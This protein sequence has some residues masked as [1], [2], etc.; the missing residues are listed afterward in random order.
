MTETQ[1]APG[2]PERE[3]RRAAA[4]DRYAIVGTPAEPAFD[5]LCQ[6]AAKLLRAPAA[7]VVFAD[8]E[9]RWCKSS[10]GFGEREAASDTALVEETINQDGVLLIEDAA[11]DPR[12]REDGWVR[13]LPKVRFFAGA[14]L[15]TPEGINVGALAVFD[16]APR[17][18]SDLDCDALLTLAAVVMD[19]AELRATVEN[20]AG[21]RADANLA[22]NERLASLGT[23]AAG[24]AHEI[25]N[26]L[27][28]VLANVGFVADRL[29]RLGRSL[30]SGITLKWADELGELGAALAEA[31]EGALR[32]RRIVR[33]LRIFSQND[34][35]KP[36]PVNLHR[37]LE[38]AITVALNEIGPRA[39]LIR[40]FGPVPPVDANEARLAQLF[41]N[42]LVNAAQ[43]IGSGGAEA[44]EIRVATETDIDGRAVVRVQDTGS[45]IAG[46][47][48]GRVFDPFFTT[49]PLGGGLG[50]G[51]FVCHGIVKGLGGDIAVDSAPG[52]GTTFRVTFPAS[53]HGGGAGPG[54]DR[55]AGGKVAPETTPLPG[56]SLSSGRPTSPTE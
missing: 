22:Q 13:G 24:V 10:C 11:V 48:I 29:D 47:A 54:G 37:A 18:P 7:V 8:G 36:V 33:D 44:N 38:S 19:E 25:N 15:R 53:E 49:K 50:L 21:S 40:Q 39:R 9:R 1:S 26:P 42:L 2:N 14:P 17:A 56:G 34:E 12:F 6:A 27:T 20:R 46:E 43:A 16:S 41:L 23:L 30:P 55:A 52:R 5:R 31:Q 45:G 4:L 3:R 28:Y 32:V 35:E 51:L